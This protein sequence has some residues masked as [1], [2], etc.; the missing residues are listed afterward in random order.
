MI[1]K[2]EKIFSMWDTWLYYHEDTYY[3]YYLTEGPTQ[4]QGWQGQ[5]VAMSVS[6]DGV[7]WEEVGVILEKDEGATALGTGSI[8]KAEDYEQSGR[9]IMNYSIW[10]D[11]C[12]ESQNIRFAE[13]TDLFHWKKL[14]EGYEFKADKRWYEVYPDC[15]QARWDCIYTI[16][17][18]GGGRYGYWTAIPKTPPGFG[19]GESLDG[20][21]WRALMPPV[22]EKAAHDENGECDVIEKIGNGECGAIEKIGDKYYMLYDGGRA[23]LVADSPEGPFYLAKKNLV[24]LNGNAYFTRF[25]PTKG[26]LLVNYH[27]ISRVGYCDLNKNILP[28]TATYEWAISHRSIYFAPLQKALVDREGTLRLTYWEGNE[29]LKN[30]AIK[31]IPADKLELNYLN[32]CMFE[33]VFN[34]NTGI[35]LEGN[36]PL[37]SDLGEDKDEHNFDTYFKDKKLFGLYFEFEKKRG[38]YIIAGR[39]GVTELGLM[40]IESQSMRRE[41]KIDREMELDEQESFRILFKDSLLE[42]YIHDVLIQ[43]YSLPSQATGRIGVVSNMEDISVSDWKAWMF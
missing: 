6:K 25:F 43:V 17:R 18:P 37:I 22:V 23:T 14:G 2:P 26:E 39:N 20:T 13:S 16:D 15:Q 27:E 24:L 29:K 5:G 36:I 7:H 21:H 35:V 8:W 42:F 40:N 34:I 1:H 4:R 38:S 30:T 11:W 28:L 33:N 19:F 3:L 31:L 12:I 32:I 10:F 41:W 9:F